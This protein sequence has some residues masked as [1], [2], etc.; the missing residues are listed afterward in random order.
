MEDLHGTATELVYGTT[1]QLPG[2][3]FSS[4]GINDTP[5]PASYVAKLKASVQQLQTSPI[6]MQPQRKLHLSKNLA[7]SMHVFV[8]HDAVRTLLQ[9]PYNGPY[10]VE[11]R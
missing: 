3:F 4:T 8:R 11:A 6:R 10:L 1:L 2:E 7:T 5:D 9:P